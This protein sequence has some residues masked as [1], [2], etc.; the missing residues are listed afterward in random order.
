MLSGDYVVVANE[1]KGLDAAAPRWVTL[2]GGRRIQLAD[3][4]PVNMRDEASVQA[5]ANEQTKSRVLQFAKDGEET[6]LDKQVRFITNTD[7]KGQFSPGTLRVE[8]TGATQRDI[9]ERKMSQLPSLIKQLANKG[10]NLFAQNY[11][12]PKNVLKAEAAHW[13]TLPNGAHIQIHGGGGKGNDKAGAAEDKPKERSSAT[14]TSKPSESQGSAGEG[15]THAQMTTIASKVADKMGI[16]PATV[17]VAEH[18]ESNEIGAKMGEYDP[19]TQ[20]ITVYPASFS[21]KDELMG[22]L[23]H[24]SSHMKLDKVL[25]AYNEQMKAYSAGESLTGGKIEI[26]KQ[27]HGGAGGGGVFAE[28]QRATYQLADGQSKYDETFWKQYESKPTTQNYLQ[29]VSETLAETERLTAGG[30]EGE[31][32]PQWRSLRNKVNGFA[33]KLGA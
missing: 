11:R 1:M 15:L 23:A 22:T 25:G 13:V 18:D 20:K 32:H 29:A 6:G 2:A 27:L 16:D 31:V 14:T 28:N 17:S 3:S 9:Y 24:E 5:A 21:S 26:Y 4:N 8:I 19:D 33:A 7:R 12:S 30:K 10:Y